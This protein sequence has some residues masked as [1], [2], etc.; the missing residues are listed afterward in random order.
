MRVHKLSDSAEHHVFDVRYKFRID[1]VPRCHPHAL[2]ESNLI[3]CYVV[4]FKAA[5]YQYETKTRYL[6][7]AGDLGNSTSSRQRLAK[8]QESLK[9]RPGIR[10]AVIFVTVNHIVTETPSLE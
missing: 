8:L 5:C 4:S 9:I 1:F 7:V 6:A 3:S 2:V 10:S